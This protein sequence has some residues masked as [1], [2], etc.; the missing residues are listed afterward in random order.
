MSA[1]AI[2]KRGRPGG[3]PQ[4]ER[5]TLALIG[6]TPERSP[7]PPAMTVGVRAETAQPLGL[8]DG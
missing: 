5:C 2:L 1:H 7:E 6:P 8:V 4:P 3:A